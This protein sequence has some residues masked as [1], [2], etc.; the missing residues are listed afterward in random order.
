VVLVPRFLI[1]D[2]MGRAPRLAD[3]RATGGVIGT[4]AV[5]ILALL[6]MLEDAFAIAGSPWTVS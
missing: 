6:A 4:T 2:G 1:G 3:G 5:V